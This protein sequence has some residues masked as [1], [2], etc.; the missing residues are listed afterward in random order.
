MQIIKHKNIFLAVSTAIV[1][2]AALGVILLGFKPGIDFTGGTLWQVEL[3]EKEV[4]RQELSNWLQGELAFEQ[5][6][7]TQPSSGGY[8]IRTTEL[9]ETEHQ[10]ALEQLTTEFGPVTELR[11]ESLGSAIGKELRDK[12]LWAFLI[13]LL[14]ISAYIA[15]AFRKVSFPISSWKYAAVTLITLFHDAIIPM[16]LFAFLGYFAGIEID[17]NFIVAMLVVVGFSVHDTIVVFDRIREK[18]RLSNVSKKG[19][20]NLVNESVNETIARSVNTS[21]TLIVVLVALYMIG[22]STLSYFVLA[23]LVG[24]LAG[25]YS[26]IFVASPLLVV[27]H[28]RAKK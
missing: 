19:F 12:A 10:E 28:D 20:A 4:S 21:I 24:T 16:G 1:V 26:S 9:T 18:L 25:T 15:Y 2:I 14:A 8:Q 17:T 7:I 11:F 3:V 22:A 5:V 6:S 27:W 13:N 23:I